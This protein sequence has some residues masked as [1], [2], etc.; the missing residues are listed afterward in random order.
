LLLAA[1]LDGLL[2]PHG[3]LYADAFHRAGAYGLPAALLV[4]SCLFLERNGHWPRLPLL[5]KIGDSSYS[6]YLTHIFVIPAAGRALG[7]LPPLPGDLCF[8]GVLAACASVAHVV[9]W[10]AEKPAD[11][12]LRSRA[13]A[14]SG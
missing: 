1:G 6:L 9:H 8:V 14:L 4:A 2:L 10:L 12:W 13:A 3:L 11:A 5:G 7:K